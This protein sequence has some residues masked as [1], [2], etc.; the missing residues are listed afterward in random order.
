MH[1]L[2]GK[3]RC[4]VCQKRVIKFRPLSPYYFEN[5]KKYSY[6][7]G[8]PETCNRDAYTC[9]RCGASD[10]NR[11][12]AIYL[13]RFISQRLDSTTSFNMLDLGPSKVLSY[14]IMSVLSGRPNFHYRTAGLFGDGIDDKVDIAD[15]RIYK[16]GQ[17]DFF[18]CS[19]VL[20]HVRD[21]RRAL[22]ELYRILRQGGRGILMVPIDLSCE[23]IDE[24]PN[25][26]DI[27][28]RWRRFGQDDHVRKY[29]K[30]G[31]IDRVIEAG[32]DLEQLGVEE[33][34][35]QKFTKHG[36]AQQSVLYIARKPKSSLSVGGPLIQ[37][38]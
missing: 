36:I 8:P 34:G 13:Q 35:L 37:S 21:D 28:E 23:Q 17:F 25:C 19:H 31:F 5:F 14:Y 29:S 7:I 27:A 38:L 30:E 4:S 22:R 1:D 11:L 12:Y 18:I 2:F 33:F 6:K 32:F 20:E 24:D 15:M 9:P 26:T 10:R 16:N 3:Y